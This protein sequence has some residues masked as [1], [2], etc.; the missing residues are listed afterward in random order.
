MSFNKSPFSFDDVKAAWERALE[1]HKGVKIPCRTRGE[2]VNLR[3]RFNYYR[4]LDRQ[5]NFQT[6]QPDDPMYGRSVYD[7]YLLRIPKKGTA[8]EAV[9]YIEPYS[10]RTMPMEVIT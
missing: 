6:Y 3:S 5:A 8:E 9:L 7:R 1:S 10:A 4:K 2:A